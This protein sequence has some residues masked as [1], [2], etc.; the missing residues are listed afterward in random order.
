MCKAWGGR[1][2][3]KEREA[4]RERE[5]A[6]GFLSHQLYSARLQS[7]LL[8]DSAGNHGVGLV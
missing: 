4:G 6:R 5:R 3:G 7:K 8:S 2:K 1:I